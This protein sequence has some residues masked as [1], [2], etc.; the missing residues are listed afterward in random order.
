MISWI[1]RTFQQHFKFI[2]AIILVVTVLSFI[3]T[4]GSTP[5]IG[6]ADRK[7]VTENFFG[8]NLAARDEYR[9]VDMDARISAM[10]RFGGISADELQ[11]YALH[12]LAGLYLADSLH[13]P[14]T[15]PTELKEFIQGLRVFQGQDGHFDA[16]RYDQFRTSLSRNNEG[17]SAAD[18]SRVIG[19]DVRIAKIETYLGGPGYVMPSGV[20]DVLMKGDTQWTLETATVPYASYDPGIKLTEAQINKFFTDNSFRYTIPPKVAVDYVAFPAVNYVSKVTA[21]DDEVKAFYAANA[22]R[23]TNPAAKPG[24]KPDAAADFAAV[25]GQV[26]STL[27][28]EKARREAVK[29]ASDFAYSLYESKVDRAS[30][31]AFLAAKGVKPSPL[32]PFTREGGPAEFSGSQEVANAAFE[33]NASRFYSEGV[34]TPGGAAVLIWRNSIASRDPLLTEVRDKVVADA[35]DNEKRTRFI[36]FGQRLRTVA[37][38]KVKAGES[39]EKAIAEAAG[40]TKVEVKSYPVFSLRTPPTPPPDSAVYQVLEEGL[41]KGAISAMQAGSDKGLLVY[42]ADKK[43]PAADPANPRLMQIWTQLSLAYARTD[44]TSLVSELVDRETK[45]VKEATK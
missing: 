18:F 29:A 27:I 34:P 7:E 11:V 42:A 21:T 2:F 43:V 24:A 37:G 12:R 14:E 31:D 15:T 26:R 32:A 1:Q 30:L 16:S 13:L 4:I 38:A 44:S 6:R 40:S 22:G 25:Q 10:L 41:D 9:R 19:D 45:R 3:F 5:G 17:A 20:Q 39:F 8:H 23:F 35:T 33:L 28:L 36:E